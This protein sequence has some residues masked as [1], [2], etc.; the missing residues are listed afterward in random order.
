MIRRRKWDHKSKL[1][2]LSSMKLAVMFFRTQASLSNSKLAD[3]ILKSS[4]K[5]ANL[6][7]IFG[8]GSLIAILLR[9]STK[10][11]LRKSPSGISPTSTSASCIR[12]L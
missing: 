2:S 7:K 3:A 10:A 6:L 12:S 8:S 9:M 5:Y 11:K 1:E 4:R